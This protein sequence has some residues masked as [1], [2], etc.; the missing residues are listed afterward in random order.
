MLTT[1]VKWRDERTVKRDGHIRGKG[2]GLLLKKGCNNI[3][4]EEHY[5][6]EHRKISKDEM[7]S[8]MNLSTTSKTI[9]KMPKQCNRI[10][11]IHEN[12]V[13]K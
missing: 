10:R 7:N 12:L 3:F 4:N 11:K 1:G 2:E 8:I 13:G 9:A 6:N 5:K